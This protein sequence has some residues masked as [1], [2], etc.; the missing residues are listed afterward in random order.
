MLAARGGEPHA[1]ADGQELKVSPVCGLEPEV[2]V[3]P[4]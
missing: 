2:L 3:L 4:P 1:P